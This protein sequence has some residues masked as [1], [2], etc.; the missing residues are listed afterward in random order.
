M[1]NLL[2][3]HDQRVLEHTC[4]GFSR[5]VDAFTHSADTL[6]TLAAHG[7]LPNIVRLLGGM[8]SDADARASRLSGGGDAPVTLS[9]GTYTMLLKMSANICRGSGTMCAQL[10]QLQVR[11]LPPPRPPA[12]PPPPRA[13]TPSPPLTFLPLPPPSAAVRAAQA[14]P[15]LDDSLAAGAAAASR[16]ADQLYQLISLSNEPR[17]S[18]AQRRGLR[19]PPPPPPPPPP[20][21]RRGGGG[22]RLVGARAKCAPPFVEARRR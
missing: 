7:L 11:R 22:G 14:H 8:V 9:D 17:R 13:P 2:S 4:V 6:E 15:P 20:G 21:G 19:L 10:L 5:L 3:H 16:P 18:R 1:T 12:G